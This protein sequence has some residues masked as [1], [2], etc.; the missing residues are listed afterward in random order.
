MV[1]KFVSAILSISA[2]ATSVSAHAFFHT[3]YVNGVSQ[4][5]LFAVRAPSSNSPIQDVSSS[6]LICNAPLHSPVSTNVIEIAPGDRFG[7]QWNHAISGPTAGDADDPIAASHKGPVIAYMAK[8]DDAATDDGS[9]LK[10]FKVAEEGLDTSTG[11][12]GVDTL[13]SNGG[14]WSFSMPSLEPGDYLLRGEIIALHSAYDVGGAQFYMSC[15]GIRVTGSGICVPTN[16]VSFPGAYDANDPSIKISIYGSSGQPDNG[17]KAYTIP[18]P[19]V[20]KCGGGNSPATRPVSSTS[21]AATS[22]RSVSISA[23]VTTKNIVVSSTTT[24]QRISSASSATS[25]TSRTSQAASK[26]TTTT[27]RAAQPTTFATVST[28]RYTWSQSETTA[29]PSSFSFSTSG[30]ATTSGVPAPTS[31]SPSTS[32]P[33]S[34][35]YTM[36]GPGGKKFLC[37]EVT[38]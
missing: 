11:K 6:A 19:A 14:L 18:G 30:T 15:V 8:V 16:T 13:I 25:T 27:S 37:Y 21:V 23:S 17:G 33:T 24:T 35:G 1:A 26:T 34:T 36:I 32:A 31:T 2:L 20:L 12:W 3:G 5:H 9:G 22:S 29:A 28:S 38:D 4:G 10:W 7:M